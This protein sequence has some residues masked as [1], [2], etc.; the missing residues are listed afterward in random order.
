MFDLK[1]NYIRTF[2]SM[3]EAKRY[4]GINISCGAISEVC[5]GKRNKAKGYIWKYHE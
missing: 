2:N 4:L 3:S 5:N 1:N